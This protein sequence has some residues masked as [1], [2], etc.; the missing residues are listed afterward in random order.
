MNNES[1]K[2][3]PACGKAAGELIEDKGA[4]FPGTAI[5]HHG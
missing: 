4:R 3:C 1:L 2:R 5:E